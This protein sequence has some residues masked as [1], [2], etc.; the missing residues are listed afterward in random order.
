MSK[1]YT[2]IINIA[3]VIIGIL[4]L[5]FYFLMEKKAAVKPQQVQQI[6]QVEAPAVPTENIT[7]A[8]AQKDLTKGMRITGGDFKLV[9]LNIAEG[10]DEKNS[11]SIVD[12][13]DSWMINSDIA[14]GAY[15]PKAALVEPGSDEY[16][17][18]SATP[19]SIVYGFSIKNSDSYLFTNAHAGGGLDIYLSYNLR[20]TVGNSGDTRTTPTINTDNDIN[21]RHF[22]L[23]M[24]DK[25]ILAISSTN[26][27]NVGKSNPL[28]NEGYVLVELTPAEVRILKGLDG[29]RLYIFPTTANLT[30]ND[31]THSVLVG[32]EGQWP[33]D[34]RD[35]LSTETYSG[36][37]NSIREYRGPG[38]A[39]TKVQ[40]E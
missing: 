8:I 33:I 39:S 12:S 11:L 22:K 23:L 40:N 25:K 31:L 4:G 20:T 14:A 5:S 32:D 13:I 18:M 9:T 19:G 16:I 3:M 2:L 27:K 30:E 26:M 36:G 28:K 10:S 1:K 37:D 29:A 38:T 6:Q 24:K 21:S 35:I 34:N 15:I 17:T 7:V